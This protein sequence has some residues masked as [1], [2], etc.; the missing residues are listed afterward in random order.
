MRTSAKPGESNEECILEIIITANVSKCKLVGTLTLTIAR[1][2]QFS[3][4]CLR[5]VS[6][7]RTK[8]VTYLIP[9]NH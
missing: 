3:S 5:Q 9:I 8:L 6:A 7:A 1:K 2:R 4:C